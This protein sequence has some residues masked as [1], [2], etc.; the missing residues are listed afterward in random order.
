[1]VQR[2]ENRAQGWCGDE[3]RREN[4]YLKDAMCENQMCGSS[5]YMCF[6]RFG[7]DDQHKSMVFCLEKCVLEYTKIAGLSEMLFN[8]NKGGKNEMSTKATKDIGDPSTRIVIGLA[9]WAILMAG[10]SKT[11]NAEKTYNDANPFKCRV[12]T[13]RFPTQK[14]FDDHF[15]NQHAK[16]ANVQ[17]FICEIC[18]KGYRHKRG[19][20]KHNNTVHL[21]KNFTCSVCDKTYKTKERLDEHMSN[22]HFE[23]NQH[24]CHLCPNRTY[25]YRKALAEHFRQ[26]HLECVEE[27]REKLSC[28]FCNKCFKENDEHDVHIAAIHS[29]NNNPFQCEFCGQFFGVKSNLTNHFKVTHLEHMCPR[30][31]FG[32]D[33]SIAKWWPKNHCTR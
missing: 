10:N 9:L 18:G 15:E 22:V 20:Q 30:V 29:D 1:M 32:R 25:T 19:L 12:C 31:Q 11:T 16:H 4:I 26:E 6:R 17:P 13:D 3:H 7:T 28:Q 33:D 23:R 8:I 2:N 24:K 21:G 14:E 27:H 5:K